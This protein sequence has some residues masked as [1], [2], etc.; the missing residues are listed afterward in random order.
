MSGAESIWE[1]LQRIGGVSNFKLE[2][3]SSVQRA[4]SNADVA[5]GIAKGS[6]DVLAV[7]LAVSIATTSTL[8]VDEVTTRA[9]GR[10]RDH[11]IGDRLIGPTLAKHTDA[12]VR[13]LVLHG[14]YDLV[15]GSERH[16]VA[17]ARLARM[18]RESYARAYHATVAW[19]QGL[20]DDAAHGAREQLMTMDGS[21]VV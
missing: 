4:L 19:M 5:L 7:L 16:V 18:R 20:A 1:W 9:L 11:L 12:R 15:R 2:R 6:A 14:Y 13:V 17:C 8:Y 10:V 21:G 3:G